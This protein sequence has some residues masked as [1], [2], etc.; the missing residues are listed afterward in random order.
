MQ[1]ELQT[2][3]AKISFLMRSLALSM[4]TETS[5]HGTINTGGEELKPG[6]SALTIL[7]MSGRQRRTA[8]SKPICTAV[9]YPRHG[10]V[11]KIVG[12]NLSIPVP[13]ISS[14]KSP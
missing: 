7:P 11:I 6:I 8:N 14:G 10:Q 5:S 4:S 2:G 1:H 12:R 3:R 13:Q 9:S